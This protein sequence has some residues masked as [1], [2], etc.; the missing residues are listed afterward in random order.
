MKVYFVFE[1]KQQFIKLYRGNE[2]VLYNILRQIYYLDKTEV[3]YGYNLFSQLVNVI[4]KPV[5]DREI[6]IKFHQD[7]PY[8]KRGDI[9]YFNNLYR[10]E[11]SRL[12][13]KNSYMRL[14]IEQ[15]TSSFFEI[16][17]DFSDSYFVCCFEKHEFFFLTREKTPKILVSSFLL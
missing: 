8:S 2:S 16:L 3:E 6:F 5:L 10:D 4:N 11:V 7:I 15:K 12:I 14:E 1:L 17:K 13:V 9:H